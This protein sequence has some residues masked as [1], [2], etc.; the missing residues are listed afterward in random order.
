MGTEVRCPIFLASLIE[1]ILAQKF[2]KRAKYGKLNVNG[3]HRD[4]QPVALDEN[5]L[6][7]NKIGFFRLTD[8]F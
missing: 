1:V 3:F 2:R 6:K 8:S 7:E 4:H 5:E